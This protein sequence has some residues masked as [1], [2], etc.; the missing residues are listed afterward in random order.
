MIFFNLYKDLEQHEADD[1]EKKHSGG[2]STKRS[3]AAEVHNLSE[4][5][6][7]QSLS[8]AAHN[9]VYS[10]NCISDHPYV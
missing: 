8:L 6:C 10:W 9:L 2:H 1:D 7:K 3:R 4:R 5:V